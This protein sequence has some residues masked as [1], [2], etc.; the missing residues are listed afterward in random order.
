[1]PVTVRK[2][3]QA[4]RAQYL[5]RLDVLEEERRRHGTALAADFADQAGERENDEVVD[6]LT[7]SA[8]AALNQIDHALE[9]A[10]QGLW[11]LCE[12]CHKAIA[13]ERLRHLP[14]ATSC[15][16]CAGRD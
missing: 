5:Q 6:A 8:R 1:M 9:R 3:L 16:N 14:E 4:R 13:A 15:A 10:D 12:I 11:G 7:V 2:E